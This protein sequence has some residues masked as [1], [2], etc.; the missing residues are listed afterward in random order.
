MLFKFTNDNIGPI[1]E[2]ISQFK[3]FEAN[4]KQ[5]LTGYFT[6]TMYSLL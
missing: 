2:K 5:M 6:K 3:F 4:Q 1:L